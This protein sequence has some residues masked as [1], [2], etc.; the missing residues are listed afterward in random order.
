MPESADAAEGQGYLLSYVHHLHQESSKVVILKVQGLKL[1]L[2]AEII[3]G[4][5]IPL[6]FHGNWVDL[7]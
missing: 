7:S 2:Q 3:L 5:H 4:V 6:G 1:E